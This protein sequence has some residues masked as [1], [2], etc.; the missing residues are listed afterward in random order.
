M[1]ERNCEH[2]RF[3]NEFT[4]IHPAPV[5]QHTGQCRRYPPVIVYPFE[6][7]DVMPADCGFWPLTRPEDWC[8]EFQAKE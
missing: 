5:G 7:H 1:S 2:C 3:W 8:G 6:M 4:D